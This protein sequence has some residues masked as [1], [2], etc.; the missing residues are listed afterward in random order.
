MFLNLWLSPP[1]QG[2]QR[3]LSDRNNLLRN[4][5]TNAHHNS[6][7]YR[8]AKTV[9][10]ESSIVALLCIIPR[11][12]PNLGLS[13]RLMDTPLFTHAS[14]APRQ[15]GGIGSKT[16]ALRLILRSFSRFSIQNEIDYS[17]PLIK[18]FL[19]HSLPTQEVGI[20]LVLSLVL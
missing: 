17:L 12:N 9:H 2:K 4:C 20:M 6:W 3:L 5:N 1:Q 15:E 18:K 19:S 7:R 16:T 8:Q 13:P 14:S 11:E 10:Y